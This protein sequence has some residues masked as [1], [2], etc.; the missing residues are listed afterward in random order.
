M[1]TS[2]ALRPRPASRRCRRQAAARLF[3]STQSL[4]LWQRPLRPSR[5]SRPR[6]AATNSGARRPT[7]GASISIIRIIICITIRPML[8]PRPSAATSTCSDIHSNITTTNNSNS[9][10]I[11]SSSRRT[12][13]TTSIIRPC[14]T[15]RR[16]TAATTATYSPTATLA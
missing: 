14:S 6:A 2:V 8:S 7:A 11:N 10:I 9:S 16:A 12:K 3:N 1:T 15:T 4:P 13:C 5:Q